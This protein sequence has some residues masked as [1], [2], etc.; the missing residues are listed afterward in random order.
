MQV[1]YL[2]EL[3]I[4]YCGT[5]YLGTMPTITT[6]NTTISTGTHVMNL[7]KCGIS[8]HIATVYHKRNGIGFV[9]YYVHVLDEQTP[10][11]SYV[12][13]ALLKDVLHR[14]KLELPNVTAAY[15]SVTMLD[16]TM[17]AK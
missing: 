5:Q 4:L 8:W 12:V 15:L 17:E 1:T 16:A 10:Q 11:D 7:G 13:A 9:R 3:H 6:L 14:I 2:H